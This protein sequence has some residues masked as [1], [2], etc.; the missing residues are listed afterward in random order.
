MK[1]ILKIKIEITLIAIRLKTNTRHVQVKELKIEKGLKQINKNQNQR[2]IF[3]DSLQ[4]HDIN[5]IFIVTGLKTT[6]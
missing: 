4:D 5:M 6:L 3:K 1:L 2:I